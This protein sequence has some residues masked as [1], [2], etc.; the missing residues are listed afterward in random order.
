MPHGDSIQ[1]YAIGSRMREADQGVLLAFFKALADE[2]RLQIVGLLSAGEYRVSDLAW[3][4]ELSEPTVS[5]HIRKLREIGLLNLRTE[6]TNRYYKLSTEMFGR[7][8]RFVEEIE[9]G[10]FERRRKAQESAQRDTAWIDALGL[11]DGARKIMRDYFVGRRLKQ[12]PTKY[13]KLLVILRYLA[14]RFEPGRRYAEVE[15]NDILNTVHEDF[16]RLRRE[17]VE[18]GFLQREG[19]GGAYWRAPEGELTSE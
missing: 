8:N 2:T 4:L 9:S 6:G 1:D 17:L 19:G 15:V 14:S 3:E 5:H 12:I 11:D 18:Q 10:E 13:T 7:L 16:A